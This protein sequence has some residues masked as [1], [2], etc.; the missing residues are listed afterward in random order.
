VV[1]A[2]ATQGSVEEAA[3]AL[4]SCVRLPSGALQDDVAVVMVAG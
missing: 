2:L 1:G 4:A 3:R